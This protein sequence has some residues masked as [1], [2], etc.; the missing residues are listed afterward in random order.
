[1]PNGMSRPVVPVKCVTATDRRAYSALFVIVSAMMYSFHAATN[2]MIAV[3]NT[4][5]AAS[6]MMTLR[7]AWPWVQPSTMAACSSSTGICRKNAV[8]FH[9]ASGSPNDSAGMISAW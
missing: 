7:N 6:G 8:R 2:A 3:V 5:G 4:P 9:T 1:M